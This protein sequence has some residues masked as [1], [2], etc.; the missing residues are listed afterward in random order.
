VKRRIL[1]LIVGLFFAGAVWGQESCHWYDMTKGFYRV[2]G[3]NASEII[4]I[5]PADGL[6]VWENTPTGGTS[7]VEANYDLNTTHWIR[8][9]HLVYT[10][11]LQYQSTQVT[12]PACVPK[13]GQTMSYADGDDGDLQ[14]GH[15]WPDRFTVQA[16]TNLV[17][18]QMTGLMWTRNTAAGVGTWEFAVSSCFFTPRHSYE[19]WR[20]PTVREMESLLDLGQGLPPPAFPEGH[21]FTHAAAY[22]WTSTSDSVDTNMAW[23]MGAEGTI[24][25][26]N[27]TNS[28]PAFWPVRTHTFGPAPVPKTGQTNSLAMGD[29]GDLQPGQPWPIPRFTIMA[30]T[31]LV[32]DNLVGRMW[33]RQ[34]GIGS[35]TSWA[36]ALDY[37]NTLDL[38]DYTDW[39]L[40]TRREVGSLID[41]GST[42]Y[43]PADHP[44][45]GAPVVPFWTST[46]Y[47]SFPVNYAWGINGGFLGAYLKT[48]MGGGVW[49]VRGDW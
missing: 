35:T 17:V 16:D 6:F 9:E 22:Y 1:V 40:P 26:W 28:A 11:Q 27:Q 31:N 4:S 37:C 38:G 20:L 7:T 2:T 48:S 13:T 36:L 43:L 10:N 8:Q 18:D 49:P 15:R 42:N 46:S 47:R 45:S 25:R 39:R 44:F 12:E 14:P 34:I 21:P 19:D 29:D 32:F 5:L 23:V 41:F 33:T 3:T 30:D 24:A